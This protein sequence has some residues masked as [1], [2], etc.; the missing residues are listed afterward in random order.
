MNEFSYPNGKHIWQ[1]SFELKRM[2]NH[3]KLGG[4]AIVATETDSVSHVEL[5]IS[6]TLFSN[7]RFERITDCRYLGR[8]IQPNGA[9]K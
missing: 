1:V 3:D 9:R 7:C 5:A 4:S 6:E 2:P 8:S